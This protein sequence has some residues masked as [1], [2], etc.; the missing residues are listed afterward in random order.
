MSVSTSLGHFIDLEL[1]ANSY[2][3]VNIKVYNLVG[4]KKI[5]LW[6]ELKTGANNVSIDVSGLSKGTY[7]VTI[8]YLNEKL[9]E[10]RI[11]LY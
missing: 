11:T 9:K 2:Q 5:S 6:E 8:S 1:F 4:E 7:R 10:E 3:S